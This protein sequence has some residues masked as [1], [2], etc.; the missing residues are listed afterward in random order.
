[1]ASSF[2]EFDRDELVAVL[3][4][5]EDNRVGRT[6]SAKAARNQFGSDEDE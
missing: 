5:E 1:M 6:M 3:K 4:A 2:V